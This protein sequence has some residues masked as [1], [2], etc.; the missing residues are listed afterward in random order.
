[1]YLQ[2][3]IFAVFLLA[4]NIYAFML[5]KSLKQASEEQ[6]EKQ[7]SGYGK[8]FVAGFLGGALAGYIA[9]FVFKFKTDSLLLMIT[10]PILIALNIYIIIALVR[11]GIL[12][13]G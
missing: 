8:L 13:F 7:K 6:G 9:M 2:Y 1:M 3:V 10:L 11:S 12:V 5:V 4:I